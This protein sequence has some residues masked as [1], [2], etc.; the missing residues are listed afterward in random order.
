MQTRGRPQGGWRFRIP[1]TPTSSQDGEAVARNN[2][3]LGRACRPTCGDYAPECFHM[4]IPFIRLI[5][6]R[7]GG[8]AVRTYVG[9]SSHEGEFALNVKLH[10]EG[11]FQAT[12]QLVS[13]RPKPSITESTYPVGIFRR[14]Q[15]ST[16]VKTT[17]IRTKERRVN[18]NTRTLPPQTQEKKHID[19]AVG[20]NARAVY[21]RTC[22]L[23]PACSVRASSRP[24]PPA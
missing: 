18:S 15:Q 22:E 10:S 21:H 23:I 5:E 3:W 4:V 20:L 1:I 12:I 9:R 2:R 6:R 13:P 16:S 19:Y 24:L 8:G 11:P 17:S 7:E 14:R